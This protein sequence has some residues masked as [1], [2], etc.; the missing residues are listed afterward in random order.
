MPTDDSEQTGK[1]PGRRRS[2]R[3]PIFAIVLLGGFLLVALAFITFRQLRA[4]EQNRLRLLTG[5]AEQ[6]ETTVPDLVARYVNVIDRARTKEDVKRR[7]E[8]VPN[9]RLAADPASPRDLHE[10]DFEVIVAGSRIELVYVGKVPPDEKPSG[11]LY[12]YRGLLDVPAVV[13]P[14]V[15]PGIFDLIVL[16]ERD[17][18]KGTVLFQHGEPELKL[19]EAGAAWEVRRPGL[20]ESL[21]N[22]WSDAATEEPSGGGT[23]VVETEIAGTDYRV[24]IQ[25]VTIHLR[26]GEGNPLGEPQEWVACGIVSW[27]RLLSSSFTTSPVLLFLMV[28]LLPLM[29]VSWPFLKM[30]LISRREPFTRFDVAALVFATLIGLA[31]VTLVVLDMV[32]LVEL[33]QEVDSQLDSLAVALDDSFET[34]IGDA[35]RQLVELRDERV[36]PPAGP[37]SAP[38]EVPT[39]RQAFLWSDSSRPD[40]EEWLPFRSVPAGR[41]NWDAVYH[42]A[43]EGVDHLSAAPL[44]VLDRRGRPPGVEDPVPRRRPA[45]EQCPRPGLLSLPAAPLPARRPAPGSRRHL[46]PELLPARGSPLLRIDPLEDHRRGS[47]GPVDSRPEPRGDSG[48]TAATSTAKAWTRREPAPSPNRFRSSPWS[49]G[50][51]P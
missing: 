50:W 5:F 33:R 10:R 37:V 26:D 28:S 24:F 49:P 32:F 2:R 27:E 20:M 7:L 13:R 6:V 1:G 8:S 23:R 4:G 39:L 43:P 29:L 48:R 9:V 35:A 36:R 34:E 47:R 45:P 44:R 3:P 11:G 30:W 21:R 25:P 14:I 51:P 19:A 22:A 42:H 18:E 38:D 15:I 41:A 17:P 40:R 31:L 46:P 12:E 16:A